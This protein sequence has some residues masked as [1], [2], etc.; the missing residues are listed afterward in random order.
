MLWRTVCKINTHDLIKLMS[1]AKRSEKGLWLGK[2]L[3]V[4]YMPSNMNIK[5]KQSLAKSSVL[6]ILILKSEVQNKGAR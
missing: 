6:E 3:C 4:K 2:V 5:T 1:K